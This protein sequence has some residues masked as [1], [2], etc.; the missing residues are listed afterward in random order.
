MS[1]SR[2]TMSLAALKARN[3][4]ALWPVTFGYHSDN[5]ASFDMAARAKEI[6]DKREKEGM[7]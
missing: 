2:A 1:D 4:R 7:K 6:E 5:R 3:C